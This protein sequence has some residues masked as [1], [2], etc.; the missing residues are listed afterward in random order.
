ML[1]TCLPKCPNSDNKLLMEHTERNPWP[2]PWSAGVTRRWEEWHVPWSA[3]N[4]LQARV[5]LLSPWPPLIQEQWD[6][7]NHKSCTING[8]SSLQKHTSG[9][10]QIMCMP[11]GV[12]AI[13]ANGTM[14]KWMKVTRNV[15]QWCISMGESWPD[16]VEPLSM[17][18]A[19]VLRKQQAGGLSDQLVSKERSVIPET[20]NHKALGNLVSLDM[21]MFWWSDTVYSNKIGI[22]FL[23]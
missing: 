2:P 1:N 15:K 4:S 21:A 18:V 8:T 23:G 13:A 11:L 3:F 7:V 22:Q 17:F 14:R 19:R 12:G 20:I 16:F 6:W 5:Y 10:E 9:L